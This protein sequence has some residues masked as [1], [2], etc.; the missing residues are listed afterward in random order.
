MWFSSFLLQPLVS[1]VEPSHTH[2]HREVL[3]L[4]V[5]GADV[6]RIGFAHNWH[7]A[8]SDALRGA[9]ALLF[10]GILTVQLDEHGVVDLRPKGIFHGIQVRLMAVRGQLH[11]MT[12]T[13]CEI[14]NKLRCGSAVAGADHPARHQLGIGIDGRPGPH[15]ADAELSLPLDR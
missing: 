11:T 1:L 13:A 6:L 3:A 12:E 14:L 7:D 2:A 5:T 8:R 4:H 10:A 15:A 9:V